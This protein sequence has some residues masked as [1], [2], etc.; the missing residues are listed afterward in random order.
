[1]PEPAAASAGYAASTPGSGHWI[2]RLLSTRGAVGFWLLFAAVH[3]SLRLFASESLSLDDARASEVVQNFALGYQVRQPPLYEWLLWGL[4][5]LFG[6]GAA[7]LF[8][9][10]YLLI[11]A[12]GLATFAAAR[13]LTS[14][15]RWSAAASLSLALSYPVAWNF[16]ELGTQTLL[17]SVACI[18]SLHAA[19]L[20]IR[21]PSAA[22]AVALGLAVGLGLMS[23]FSY[24]LLL[25][26]L[27]LAAASLPDARRR[28]AD[29]RLLLAAAVAFACTAPYLVWLF[30]VRGDIVAMANAHLVRS[31]EPH[32]LRAL[33]GLARLGWSLPAFLM[34]WLAIVALL[35]WPAFR[36]GGGGA[37]P[38]TGERIALRA[39]L[40]AALLA[41]LGIVALGAT[42]IGERYMHAIL[43]IAPVYVFARIARVAPEARRLRRI[44]AISLACTALLL[45]VRVAS[46]FENDVTRRTVR[47]FAIPYDGLAAELVER[48][49]T[50]GT[51]I[52]PS[53]REAGNMRVYIPALRVMA[54][55]TFRVERPPRRAGDARSCVLL[56][57][58]GEIDWVRARAPEAA[59]SAER[60][61]VVTSSMWGVRRGAWFF[62]KLDPR[63]PACS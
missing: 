49:V 12:I 7:S 6:V 56:W 13:A 50:E 16:H 5:Q 17:L 58:G 8:L 55:D 51:L 9:L 33:I 62:A 36:P 19:V 24:P 40:F 32:A 18:V 2:D 22:S 37:P 47:G 57:R 10:R 39:M 59:G 42:N 48:G 1:M 31:A 63:A 26:G 46:F 43:M 29:R 20:F 23:K 54:G 41:A 28:L 34:P 35:A 30:Q 53:V 3:V 15:Q 52:A 4:Q 60:I 21:R 27:L 38:G 61:E 14:E 11:A 25:G 44:A 45:A